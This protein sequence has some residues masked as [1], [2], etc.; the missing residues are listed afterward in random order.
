M[1]KLIQLG[2]ATLLLAV[3]TAALAQGHYGGHGGGH[4][5][6]S[7]GGGHSGFHGGGH[8]VSHLS[9][10]LAGFGYRAPYSGYGYGPRHYDGYA[11][12]SP[13]SAP[14]GYYDGPARVRYDHHWEGHHDHW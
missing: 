10:G 9:V 8:R 12:P 13:Y 11:Y 5:G 2:A 6:G 3:P 4:Y 14:Y 7:H 1:K